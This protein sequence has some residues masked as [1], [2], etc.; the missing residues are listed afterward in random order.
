M[1]T[2]SAVFLEMN[3][4]GELVSSRNAEICGQKQKGG[5]PNHVTVAVSVHS[6]L[7]ISHEKRFGAAS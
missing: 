7:E 5:P 2:M 4:N 1:N 6:E 3:W